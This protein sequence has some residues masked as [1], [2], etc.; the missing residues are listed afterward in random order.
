MSNN[1]FV[2]EIAIDNN[3]KK[4][5]SQANA[6]LDNGT[7]YVYLSQE[8]EKAA[9][10]YLNVYTEKFVDAVKSQFKAPK[11]SFWQKLFGGGE[12]NEVKNVVVLTYIEEF[13]PY[14]LYVG[15]DFKHSKHMGKEELVKRYP[16]FN[17]LVG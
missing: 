16:I 5:T 8:L 7:L 13:A 15:N 1:K 12:S 4:A 17:E 3:G 14:Q 10:G 2:G 11:K 6:K 9:P